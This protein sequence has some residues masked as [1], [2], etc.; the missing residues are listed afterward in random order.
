M[1]NQQKILPDSQDEPQNSKELPKELFGEL[2]QSSRQP[3]QTQKD[4]PH[5]DKTKSAI[6]TPMMAQYLKIKHAYPKTLLFYRMGDFYE[7]FFDDAIKAAALLDITLTK[8]GKHLGKDIPMCGV[9][10]HAVD[11][12]THRLIRAGEHIAICEQVE[13]KTPEK[14]N[15]KLMPRRVVRILTQGT[16]TEDALLEQ[17]EYN[18]LLS[19]NP[20][21]K[22]LDAKWGIA[23]ADISTGR[24]CVKNVATIQDLNATIA[25]LQPK[26]ILLSETLFASLPQK[27]K[28]LLE[29]FPLTEV[30]NAA[31]TNESA[32]SR[33]RENFGEALAQEI[34]KESKEMLGAAGALLDYIEITQMEQTTR[35]SP[36]H[37]EKDS[38]FMMMDPSTRA[39]LEL[40]QPLREAQKEA[41]L[42]S[43]INKTQT[44][45]GARLLA[46]RLQSPL[47]DIAQINHRLDEI[48]FFCQHESLT[49]RISALL[50]QTPDMARALARLSFGRALPKDLAVLRDGLIATRKITELLTQEN[51]SSLPHNIKIA[52]GQLNQPKPELCFKLTDALE[53]NLPAHFRDGGII[54]VNYSP[55]L[56]QQRQNAKEKRNNISLLQNTYAE[57]TKVKQLK[58]KYNN[59]L[60]FFVEVS[61]AQGNKLLEAPLNKIFIHR[62]TLVNHL[63]FTT[64]ELAKLASDELESQAA[65]L[66]QE[67]LLCDELINEALENYHA[68]QEAALAIATLDIATSY[69][70]LAQTLQLQRPTIDESENFDIVAGRHLVVEQALKK[71][72]T[73]FIHNDCRLTPEK[74]NIEKTNIEKKNIWLLTG[75]NMAGKSTFLRQNA[76]IAVMAHAGFFVPA[77]KA[78]IGVIDRLFS[79]IGAADNLA[80]GQS[81][82]MVEMVETAIILTQATK[83]SFVI[84]DEVG[85]GTSTFDGLALAWA[86]V[87]F[88][89]QKLQ[90][91]ALFATHFHELTL[92][93]KTLTRLANYHMKT[94]SGQE[95]NIHLL[96]E[97]GAGAALHSYG[98]QIAKR[99]GLPE[100]VVARASL[101]L[102]QLEKQKSSKN[103]KQTIEKKKIKSDAQ[104]QKE[105]AIKEKLNALDLEAL[106]PLEALETLFQMKTILKQ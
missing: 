49:A 23:W 50:K 33:L 85:R 65:F 67:K 63:R 27:I 13:N 46:E 51:T 103:I 89:C 44:S 81:T 43:V 48:E 56:D 14:Q 24:F 61:A 79:R 99:A 58:I 32:Q 84:I 78:H 106:T 47:T 55:S 7:L 19:I 66:A 17:Q 57:K 104:E 36:P 69:A 68:I 60:G 28:N 5:K 45:S 22:N 71:N 8:R 6:A 53:T 30:P 97:V 54:R 16:L 3:Q 98:I 90:C 29:T 38:T 25:R 40:V 62:Q 96:Y 4:F 52:L 100:E 26:E 11:T 74:T 10:V 73:S 9:P 35:L 34:S 94:A 64:E 72:Q 93:D 37:I 2:S 20:N 77:Q 83:R 31:F 70:T 1:P 105:S 59:I 21:K 42:F 86:I 82:F 12:Y 91:R 76:I 87:E 18:Y 41:S 92:L 75:P 80:Y 102:E 39:N 95:K 101:L 15:T 88:M